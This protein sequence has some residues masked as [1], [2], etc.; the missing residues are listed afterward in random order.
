MKTKLLRLRYLIAA[1]LL[2]LTIGQVKAATFTYYDIT[3]DFVLTSSTLAGWPPGQRSIAPSTTSTSGILTIDNGV[4]YSI[5]LSNNITRLPFD[6][7]IGPLGNDSVSAVG[8][9]CD[10]TCYIGLT[11]PV[12]DNGAITSGYMTITFPTN[13]GQGTIFY[14]YSLVDGSITMETPLPAALPLFATGLGA[15]GLLGWRRKKK[16]IAA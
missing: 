16:A 7:L 13:D 10:L 15:L 12:S 9:G 8:G 6:L 11:F 2:V 4:P 5:N 14:N 3:A 1:C